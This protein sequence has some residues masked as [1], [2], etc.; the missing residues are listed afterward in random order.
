L[1]AAGMALLSSTCILISST[2]SS[3]PQFSTIL[4]CSY[5]YPS[6]DKLQR[7]MHHLKIVGCEYCICT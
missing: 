5:Y 1:V 6:T 7:V 4:H 2:P 3:L